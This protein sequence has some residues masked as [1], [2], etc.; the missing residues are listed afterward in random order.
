[1]S[2]WKCHTG[3]QCKYYTGR[4]CNIVPASL[5]NM[6]CTGNLYNAQK[7]KRCPVQHIF[8][9]RRGLVWKKIY[10]QPK[11]EQDGCRYV[12]YT[13]TQRLTYRRTKFFVPANHILLI[14]YTGMVF[15]LY[16]HNVWNTQLI[17][18]QECFHTGGLFNMS[19]Y[20]GTLGIHNAMDWPPVL[21][22]TGV[23]SRG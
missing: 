22:R 16:R 23:R 4:R 10:R 20:T 1:M 6:N 15:F 12:N 21:N 7:V 2:S 9:Y 8:I 5:R 3:N 14:L 18:A 11:H 19:R 13:G 17:P